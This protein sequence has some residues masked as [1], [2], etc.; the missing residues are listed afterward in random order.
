MT[1]TNRDLKTS[2]FLLSDH[3]WWS[4][5]SVDVHMMR[6]PS[7]HKDPLWC[8]KKFMRTLGSEESAPSTQMYCILV[9]TTAGAAL[10]E[11]SRPGGSS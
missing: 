9:M 10:N 7:W 11:G 5:F 6:D 4:V 1:R 8:A 2:S 3:M